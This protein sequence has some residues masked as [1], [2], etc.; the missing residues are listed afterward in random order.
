MS[1]GN[2]QDKFSSLLALMIHCK[3]VLNL[4]ILVLNLIFFVQEKLFR[5]KKKKTNRSSFY[6][7]VWQINGLEI[8]KKN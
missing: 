2:Y 7:H 1:F 8:E 4:T 5:F 3:T 6:S